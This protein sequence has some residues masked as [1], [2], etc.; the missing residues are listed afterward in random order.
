[1]GVAP[2][3]PDFCL[4]FAVP[5]GGQALPS[6][7]GEPFQVDAE[8]WFARLAL[9]GVKKGQVKG[10]ESPFLSRQSLATDQTILVRE[11]LNLNLSFSWLL[12]SSLD[13][14]VFRGHSP[15]QLGRRPLR[16]RQERGFQNIPAHA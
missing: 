9:C 11:R 14:E 10:L 6:F 3:T 13:I 16:E 1:M 8:S 12:I 2:P 15:C 5:S 4:S 7:L